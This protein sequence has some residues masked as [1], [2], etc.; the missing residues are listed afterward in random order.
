MGLLNPIFD[1][2]KL[3]LLFKDAQFKSVKRLP[4]WLAKGEPF[5]AQIRKLRT[6]LG[7]TQEQLA[8]RASQNSRMIRRLES[9]GADPQLS[10]L[11]KTAKGLEC[12][13][14]VRLVPREP[15]VKLLRNRARRKA[16]R[17]VRLSKGTAAMEEQ[18]PQ[19]KYVKIE[20]DRIVEELL[21]K[22]RRSL[23]ED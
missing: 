21:D 14:I 9:D 22:R 12:E 4:D 2:V 10:T 6:T 13:L 8:R 16:E 17:I 18:E 19:D 1:T 23:W 5:Y 7:M 15:I 3:D 20:I 11:Q